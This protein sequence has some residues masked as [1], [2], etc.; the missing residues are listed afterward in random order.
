MSCTIDP[1]LFAR[2]LAVQR[3]EMEAHVR[4]GDVP[5]DYVRYLGSVYE[6]LRERGCNR[7]ALEIVRLILR[8]VG[9][10]AGPAERVELSYA[11]WRRA[12]ITSSFL[13]LWQESIEAYKEAIRF[14]EIGR[15]HV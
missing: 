13:G 6:G 1:D 5:P 15:A 9:Y 8:G 12:A 2:A 3:A 10:V 7:E 4:G 11:A 14:G